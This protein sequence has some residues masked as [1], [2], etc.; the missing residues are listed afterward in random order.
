MSPGTEATGLARRRVGRPRDANVD[1]RILESVREVLAERGYDGLTVQEVTR[2]S[3]AHAVTVGR[4]WP[5]KA[6]LVAAAILRD[7]EPFLADGSLAVPTGNLR[8]DLTNMVINIRSF[9]MDPSVRAALPILWSEV[10]N[11]PAVLD[12]VRQRR[13]QWST[14]VQSVLSAAVASGDAPDEVLARAELVTDVLA[15]TS[16]ARQALGHRVMEN[17][18][19]GSLIELVMGGLIPRR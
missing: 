6:G 3:G 16:F 19:V 5:T 8:A 9:L 10:H 17:A 7:D 2:R 11:D 4:R 12:R 1:H 15:G 14:L 13:E 18:D